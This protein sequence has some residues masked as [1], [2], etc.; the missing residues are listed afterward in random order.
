MHAINT[1]RVY[2]PVEK[3]D[4]CRVLVDRLWPRGVKKEDLPHDEWLKAVAPS[5]ELRQWFR[6]DP[7]RFEEFTTRYLRELKQNAD[8]DRL[9]EIAKGQPLTLLF[10]A[11]DR[12]H[13]QAQVLANYIQQQLRKG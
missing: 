11:K 8:V 13:N 2:D 10:S 9:V 7:E 4:G 12:E 6:H 1:K 5:T 3:S